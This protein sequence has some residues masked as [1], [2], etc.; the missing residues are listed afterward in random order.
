MT[1]TATFFGVRSL[2]RDPDG[3]VRMNNDDPLRWSCEFGHVEHV[4]QLLRCGANANASD[5]RGSAL[6]FAARNGHWEV[7]H[8]L[9]LHG[10]DVS[11]FGFLALGDAV[12]KGHER[13]AL[14]LL[15]ACKPGDDVTVTNTRCFYRDLI[16][17]LT[18]QPKI[19]V[20]VAVDLELKEVLMAL[21]TRT[22]RGRDHLPDKYGMDS[23]MRRATEKG[24]SD[25]VDILAQF[26]TE[27][28]ENGTQKIVRE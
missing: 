1:A 28:S 20:C 17:V 7:V 19:L 22:R 10:A 8:E 5:S 12:L 2:L 14:T 4:K 15:S 16:D 11:A 18:L 13:V 9:L 3:D 21:L 26:Y 25:I 23:L 24:R 6:S 27:E